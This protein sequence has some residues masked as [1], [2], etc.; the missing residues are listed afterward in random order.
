[1]TKHTKFSP[2]TLQVKK[3]LKERRLE[4]DYSMNDARR[5]IGISRKM[6]EDIEATREYG[7]HLQLETII[8][9]CVAY[10]IGL[11]DVVTDWPANPDS[12]LLRKPRKRGGAAH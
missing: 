6:L 1:M 4:L 3:A 9:M 7:C 8:A 2:I 12:P 5:L 11:E 10:G